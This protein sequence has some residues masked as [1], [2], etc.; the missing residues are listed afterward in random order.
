MVTARYTAERTGKGLYL[1]S[2][3]LDE[4][5]APAERLARVMEGV[6]R[7]GPQPLGSPRLVE[8]GGCADAFE[9]L[10]SD[11]PE[12]LFEEAVAGTRAPD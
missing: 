1:V 10:M 12:E 4:G 5:V 9:S 7:R 11:F 2:R 3:L 6:V 8:L